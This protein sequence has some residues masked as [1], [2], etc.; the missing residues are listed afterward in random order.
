MADI[1]ELLNSSDPEALENL[2]RLRDAVRLSQPYGATRQSLMSPAEQSAEVFKAGPRSAAESAEVLEGASEAPLERAAQQSAYEKLF[3][4]QAAQDLVDG[5]SVPGKS[6]AESA[7][8]LGKT[9]PEG[10]AE[11][12]NVVPVRSLAPIAEAG[13]AAGGSML[14]AAGRIAGKI[15]SPAALAYELL[16]SEPGHSDEQEMA[17]REKLMH[18][19]APPSLTDLAAPR[20]TLKEDTNKESPIATTS[21]AESDNEDDAPSAPA[22]EAD[23]ARDLIARASGKT[24]IRSRMNTSDAIASLL[25]QN[26]TDLADAKEERN[27]KQLIAMLN[28]AGNTI[29]AAITPMGR[30]KPDESFTKQLIAQADQPVNDLKLKKQLSQETLNEIKAQKELASHDPTSAESTAFRHSL[31]Q[32]PDLVKAYGTD[33]ENITAAD[34]ENIY[35]PL[36]LKEKIESRKL[37]A[38]Q[39]AHLK[40]ESRDKAT[41]DKQFGNYQKIQTALESNRANTPDV[42]QA[43]LDRYNASK[44]LEAFSRYKNLNDVPKNIA[45]LVSGEVGKIATGGVPTHEAMKALDKNTLQSKFAEY[46][47]GATGKIKP[48]KLGSFLNAYTN[49]L[50]DLQGNANKLILQKQGRIIN[51]LQPGDVSDQKL[52]YLQQEYLKDPLETTHSAGSDMVSVTSP[53]GVVGSI[54]RANLKKAIERKFIVNE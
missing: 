39:L 48:A 7:E 5:A 6:A 53:E 40:Q 17:E 29:G 9:L 49:Y 14:G 23:K 11:G 36:E 12:R 20:A 1:S 25:G 26:R 35:K 15:A 38:A 4:K 32:F 41:S 19:D 8:V 47:E 33:F 43:Y 24:P 3:S 46:L 37:A 28:D 51:G 22:S 31:R 10:I 16:K 13:E 45:T 18:G 34:R 50:H 21:P 52:Q 42:K 2:K 27:R 44:G 54:P 30:T